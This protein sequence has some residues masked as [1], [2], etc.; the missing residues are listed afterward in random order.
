MPSGKRTSM[1]RTD[2]LSGDA[3]LLLPPSYTHRIHPRPP[4]VRAGGEPPSQL[5]VVT[6]NLWAPCWRR[7]EVPG[8]RESSRREEWTTRVKAQQRTLRLQLPDIVFLQEWWHAN[9]EYRELWEE[10]CRKER[11]VMFSSPRTGRKQDGV[12]TLV[13]KSLAGGARLRTYGFGDWGDRVAQLVELPA[14]GLV[15]CNTHLTFPHRNEWD[16]QMRY[17]QARK[18]A[19]VLTS[20]VIPPYAQLIL[21]G[22]LNGERGD[23]PVELLFR[24]ARLTPQAASGGWVS[25]LNHM[26]EKVGYDFIAVRGDISIEGSKLVGDLDSAEPESDHLL[27]KASLSLPPRARL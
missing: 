17:H 5:C 24:A 2:F 23:T 10:F 12:L 7:T 15:L 19:A 14:S 27:V 4:S 16:P 8:G 20:S 13:S 1:R 25:H 11:F 3:V 18:L 26:G 22:D 21:A 9:D 6:W